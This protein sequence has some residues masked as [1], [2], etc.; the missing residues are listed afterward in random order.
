MKFAR[1]QEKGVVE[2]DSQRYRER[3]SGLAADAIWSIPEP[4][5]TPPNWTLVNQ[6]NI[7]YEK[8]DVST[9]FFNLKANEDKTWESS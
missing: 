5:D 2:S 3:K 6:N 8:N 1:D 7:W 9:E 4:R